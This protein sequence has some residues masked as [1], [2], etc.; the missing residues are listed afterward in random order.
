MGADKSNMNNKLIRNIEE[1]YYNKTPKKSLNKLNFLKKYIHQ[2][3]Y[4]IFFNYWHKIYLKK[5]F[6]TKIQ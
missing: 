6:L 4:I 3:K 5:T 2:K 1:T